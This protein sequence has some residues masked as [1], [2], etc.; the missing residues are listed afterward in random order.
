[1]F[2][3]DIGHPAEHVYGA[4][5]LARRNVARALARRVAEKEMTEAEALDIARKW[6]YR[7]PKEL[8]QLNV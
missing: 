4:L 5:V 8:Y 7:N 2:G 1:V 3:G 6:F